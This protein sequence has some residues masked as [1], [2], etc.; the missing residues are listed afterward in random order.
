MLIQNG[1]DTFTGGPLDV[2]CLLHDVNTGR[3]HACFL[4]ERPFPGP[5]VPVEQ[6]GTVRL[7]SK[8]HHTGGAAS[9]EEGLVHLGELSSRICVL[10]ENITRDPVKWDGQL[11]F[12]L[13]VP[14]WRRA[15]AITNVRLYVYRGEATR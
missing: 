3:F 13:L 6:L 4:E 1:D 10:P 14:N 7:V 8:M 9:Y 11:G 2:L 15:G 5:V 12:V